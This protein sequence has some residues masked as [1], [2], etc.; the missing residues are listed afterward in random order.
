VCFTPHDWEQR[1]TYV[2]REA[3]WTADDLASAR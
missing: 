1:Q 2:N 3:G